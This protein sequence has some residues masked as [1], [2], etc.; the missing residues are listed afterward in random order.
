MGLAD[1][2]QVLPGMCALG[3]VFT[4]DYPVAMLDGRVVHLSTVADLRNILK[5]PP[6]GIFTLIVAD[7]WMKSLSDTELAA[8]ASA[9]WPSLALAGGEIVHFSYDI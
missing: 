4:L 6:N 5:N 2:R 7:G 1:V 9:G 8:E 3:Q